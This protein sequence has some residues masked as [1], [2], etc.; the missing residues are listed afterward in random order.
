[1]DNTIEH[2][3]NVGI[4]DITTNSKGKQLKPIITAGKTYRYNKDK[5]PTKIL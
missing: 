3:I 1:M 5:P 2:I 4:G